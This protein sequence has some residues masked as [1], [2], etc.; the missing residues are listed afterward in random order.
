MSAL[1]TALQGAPRHVCRVPKGRP[2]FRQGDAADSVLQLKEGC[3]RLEMSDPWGRRQILAFLFPND[4]LWVG[5]E[6]RWAAAEAVTDCVLTRYGG[7]SALHPS[8]SAAPALL[9]SAD[10]LM[11]EIAQH[12]TL[13]TRAPAA[14]RF[15]QFLAWLAARQPQPGVLHLPMSREDIADFLGIAPG[16]VSRQLRQFVR[17]GRLRRLGPRR[18]LVGLV[19]GPHRAAPPLSAAAWEA[20]S[21][22]QPRFAS[23]SPDRMDS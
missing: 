15:G 7:V 6:R 1:G 13:L 10:C 16:T 8:A 12:L 23:A 2:V 17:E 18:Y 22:G 14:E 21:W 19:D 4:I 11:Q 3:V 20:R 9:A 5:Y